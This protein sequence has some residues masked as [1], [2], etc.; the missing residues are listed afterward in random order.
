MWSKFSGVKALH[1]S[2]L[3]VFERFAHFN[4]LLWFCIRD[5]TLCCKFCLLSAFLIIMTSYITSALCCS[6]YTESERNNV[7][8]NS[9]NIPPWMTLKPPQLI[10]SHKVFDKCGK[11]IS[12]LKCDAANKQIYDSDS[13]DIVCQDHCLCSP[14]MKVCN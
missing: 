4:I 8:N 14:Y 1:P 12:K 2:L 13:D 11:K 5:F 9:R 6:P 10:S 7:R 3:W